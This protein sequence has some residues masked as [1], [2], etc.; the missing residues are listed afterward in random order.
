MSDFVLAIGSLG[1]WHTIAVIFIVF[2][3]IRVVGI[4]IS[5]FYRM[6][7]VLCRG[8]PPDHLDADGDWK[9]VPKTV[10]QS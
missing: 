10:A 7:M 2:A 5:R 8:W 6:I 9:P 3:L 1:F 4:L